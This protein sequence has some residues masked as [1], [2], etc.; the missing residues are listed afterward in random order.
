MVLGKMS[1]PTLTLN[2]ESGKPPD[3]KFSKHLFSLFWLVTSITLGKVFK[4][5]IQDLFFLLTK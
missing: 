2:K 1:P 3:Q 5:D 4:K